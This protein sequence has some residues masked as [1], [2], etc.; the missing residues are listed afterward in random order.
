MLITIPKEFHGKTIRA[1]L[2]TLLFPV[3]LQKSLLHEKKITLDGSDAMVIANQR[4]LEIDLHEEPTSIPTSY[5]PID[6]VWEDEHFFI[7]NKPAGM[8]THPNEPDEKDT[9]LNFAAYHVQTEGNVGEVR[10][11]HRLDRDTSGVLVVAKHRLSYAR[12]STLLEE[13]HIK[14]Y[15]LAAVKG[16][17]PFREKTIVA[18]IGRDRHH[19]TKRRISPNGQSAIT[20][21]TTIGSNSTTTWLKCSLETGRTHQI[22]VHLASIGFPVIGDVLYGEITRDPMQ[23]HAYAIQFSHPFTYEEIIVSTE[24]PFQVPIEVIKKLGIEK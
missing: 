7:I 11:V 21:V 23:L 14:R 6:I 1:F 5:A 19:P 22:R 24:P 4:F 18:T 12:L 8:K 10:T 9:L 15:Y 2:D 3:S 20:H 13:N 17:L 16:K